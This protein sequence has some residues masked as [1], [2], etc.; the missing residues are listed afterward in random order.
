MERRRLAAL[1]I[2]AWLPAAHLVTLARHELADVFDGQGRAVRLRCEETLQNHLVAGATGNPQPPRPQAAPVPAP[3]GRRHG[4]QHPATATRWQRTLL[5]FESVRLAR[6]RYSLTMRRRYRFSDTGALRP[7]FLVAL[8][9]PALISIPMVLAAG[10]RV[11]G[12][13]HN[14]N[15]HR[16]ELRAAKIAVCAATHQAS[17]TARGHD[18]LERLFPG[19]GECPNL[20]TFSFTHDPAPQGQGATVRNTSYQHRGPASETSAAAST[21]IILHHTQ[22]QN[23]TVRG[24]FSQRRGLHDFQL[25]GR[26]HA[27]AR[28]GRLFQLVARRLPRLRD[29]APEGCGR[30][31]VCEAQFPQDQQLHRHQ[32]R[33]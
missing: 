24:G 27:H 1:H 14:R 9:P 20:A 32:D 22:L 21:S 12:S 15:A 33:L 29:D 26:W 3:R 5:N 6:K 13:S 2:A 28:C 4:H 11:Q 7:C 17:C 19:K 16:Q 8:R 10:R 30:R 25:S 23:Y 18:A 31:G